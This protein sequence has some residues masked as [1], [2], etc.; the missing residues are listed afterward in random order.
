M[1]KLEAFT[2]HGVR[3]ID[4]TVT[5]RFIGKQDAQANTRSAPLLE[6]L[7]DELLPLVLRHRFHQVLVAQHREPDTE[8]KRVTK[9]GIT[10]RR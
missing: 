8:H 5:V 3:N 6:R 4:M 7:Q 2:T 9:S 10:T 1:R